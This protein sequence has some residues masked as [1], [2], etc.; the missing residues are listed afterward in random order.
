PLLAEIAEVARELNYFV[1][2]ALDDDIAGADG[3]NS[4]IVRTYSIDYLD[5]EHLYKVV[6]TYI[7]PKNQQKRAL[8]HDIY[9]YFREV[10][11]TFRWSEQKFTALYPLHPAILEVAPFVRLYIHDFALLGFASE[12]G[13]RIR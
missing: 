6:D 3:T 4:A 11:P 7:F 13:E 12:A 8:L 2:V 10:I 5:Q 1:G 9:E